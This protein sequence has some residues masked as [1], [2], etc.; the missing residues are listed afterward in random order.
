[1]AVNASNDITSE[2][3]ELHTLTGAEYSR[4]VERI[5]KRK[6]FSSLSD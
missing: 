4:Q 6:E 1:M 5:A 2:L 3:E